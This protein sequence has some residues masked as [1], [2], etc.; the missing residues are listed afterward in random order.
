MG[1]GKFAVLFPERATGQEFADSF[2]LEVQSRLGGV[3]FEKS[4][5]PGDQEEMV[6]AVRLIF[7][8][9]G[10]NPDAKLKDEDMEWPPLEDWQLQA[11]PDAIFIPDTLEDTLP[12]LEMVRK[13]KRKKKH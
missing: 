10:I 8:N 12:I 2:R 11:L 6:S 4:Y 9:A 7:A 5:Y 1:L 13:V 3:Q